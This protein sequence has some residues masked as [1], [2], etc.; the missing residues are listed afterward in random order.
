MRVS[1][2]SIMM[3]QKAIGNE[4]FMADQVDSLTAKGVFPD[5]AWRN[6]LNFKHKF[7]KEGD[8]DG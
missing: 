3:Y 7:F 2:F 5:Y 6:E 4:E 8:E 1:K